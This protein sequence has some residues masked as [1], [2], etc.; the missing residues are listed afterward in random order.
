MDSNTH[1]TGGRA[2]LAAVVDGAGR[3]GPRPPGAGPGPAGAGRPPGGPL[4]PGTGRG[5]CPRGGRGRGGPPGALDRSLAAG[6]APPGARAAASAVRTARELFR[7][8]LAV[9]AQ[10]LTE[11]EL[12]PAHAAVLA[13]GTHALPGEVAVEAEPVLLEAARRLDPPRLPTGPG[14]PAAGRRPRGEP[15]QAELA[16][17]A[18]REVGCPRAG[19]VRPSCRSRW[20]WTASWADWGRWGEVGGAGPL[21]PEA[22]ARLACDGTVTGAGH[23]P[24]NLRR[25]RRPRRPS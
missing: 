5:R 7:G 1:S 8:P 11:G 15:N 9:T 2:D 12:S 24:P 4:A 3:P 17:R 22:A 10:A 18:W 20:T 21:D 13:Q 16:R 6:P 25:P 23:R 19:G 14:P